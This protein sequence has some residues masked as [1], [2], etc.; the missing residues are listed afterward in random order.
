MKRYVLPTAIVLLTVNCA[1]AGWEHSAPPAGDE[2]LTNRFGRTWS[3]PIYRGFLIMDGQ[4][5]DAPY[6]VEQRG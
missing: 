6:V 5:I 2:F 1:L 4:Y 3:E